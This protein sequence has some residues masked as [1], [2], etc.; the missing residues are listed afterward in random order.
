VGV[1]APGTYD[2]EEFHP[3]FYLGGVGA[4]GGGAAGNLV[5]GLRPGALGGEGR[6]KS[7]VLGGSGLA[8]HNF[9]HHGVGLV[10]GEV[11]FADDFDNGFFDHGA[12]PFFS[13]CL[14]KE[15]KKSPL[16]E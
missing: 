3:G 15:N 10:I 8:A 14:P 9:I 13:P 12:S 4:H 2:L 11:P 5:D 16:T 1:V 6:E 7:G